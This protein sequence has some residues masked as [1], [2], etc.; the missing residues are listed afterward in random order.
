MLGRSVKHHRDVIR[1]P[2]LLES[3]GDVVAC[4]GLLC[5][6][7]GD[8]V[9]LGGDECDELDT[10]F[11]QQIAS[12]FGESDTLLCG[13][14]LG[15]NLLNSRYEE[16]QWMRVLKSAKKRGIPFGSD[17]SSLP[18]ETSAWSSLVMH[19]YLT[20]L[21]F[22]LRPVTVLVRWHN[23]YDWRMRREVL[24]LKGSSERG[25][26]NISLYVTRCIQH[27]NTVHSSCSDREKKSAT[28]LKQHRQFAVG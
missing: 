10:A 4:D 17:R 19:E 12:F 6:F 22:V 7:F 20:S 1:E 13:Q 23:G 28:N 24:W 11:D 9:C 16:S 26:G 5:L 3:L 25:D 18:V 21:R 2:E 27:C 15:D 8:L 14:N